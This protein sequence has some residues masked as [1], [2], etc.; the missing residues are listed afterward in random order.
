MPCDDVGVPIFRKKGGSKYTKKIFQHHKD[1]IVTLLE[2]E[3]KD[4]NTCKMVAQELYNKFNLRVSES[5]VN[6]VMHLMCYTK[7]KKTHVS[8]TANSEKNL[9]LR[10]NYA[11]KLN[12]YKSQGKK[13]IY[14]DETNY[15]LHCTMSRAWSKKGTR[16]PKY[17]VS[18]KGANLS[19]LGAISGGKGLILGKTFF[20]SC[21]KPEHDQWLREVIDKTETMMDISNVVFVI[22]N[23]S[24]HSAIEQREIYLYMLSK[25]CKLLRLGPYSAPL[26]PIE[27]FWNVM[28]SEIKQKVGMSV[29]LLTNVPEGMTQKAHRGQL[30]IQWA[31]EALTHIDQEKCRAFEDVCTGRLTACIQMQPLLS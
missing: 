12:N 13:I 14:L 16:A 30:M 15:N 1:Y 24:C 20:G 25:G 31:N 23:A 22:D 3:Y 6:R 5:T 8:D 26:N 17:R 18:S 4:Y 28:K 29:D 7:K 2:D 9:L 27:L 19:I 10:R 11:I 21:K